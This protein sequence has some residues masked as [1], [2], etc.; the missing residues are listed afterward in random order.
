MMSSAA[1]LASLGKNMSIRL[2][3]YLGG[4]STGGTLVLLVSECTDRF[5]AIFSLR[6]SR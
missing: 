2:T 1:G 5:R 4:H 6:T 3:I